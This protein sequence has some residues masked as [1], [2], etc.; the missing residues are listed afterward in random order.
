MDLYEKL[1]TQ[2]IEYDEL[3]AAAMKEYVFLG[4]GVSAIEAI[5][6]PFGGGVFK[7]D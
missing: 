5:K 4:R 1:H 6:D 7:K 2:G 3:E